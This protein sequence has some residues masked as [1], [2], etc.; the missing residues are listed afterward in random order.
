MSMSRNWGG[1]PTAADGASTA[2]GTDPGR[3]VAVADAFLPEGVALFERNIR[4]LDETFQTHTGD[5]AE[6]IPLVVLVF[7]IGLFPNPILSR[8]HVSVTNVVA[9]A[10]HGPQESPTSTGQVTPVVE[11]VPASQTVQSMEATRP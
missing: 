7:W 9:R 11:P 1:S 2:V 3:T 4:G 10:T 8:M 5:V 6:T